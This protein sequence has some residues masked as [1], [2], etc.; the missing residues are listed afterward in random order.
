MS[1]VWA[2]C[3]TTS[4]NT[5]SEPGLRHGKFV[6]SKGKVHEGVRALLRGLAFAHIVRGEVP[7]FELRTL[8]HA[9]AGVED[10]HGHRSLGT[11]LGPGR[12]D[13]GAKKSRHG[14]SP[15]ELSTKS[16]ETYILLRHTNNVFLR[17]HTP[18]HDRGA[19]SRRWL[20][21]PGSAEHRGIRTGPSRFPVSS[22]SPS[23]SN[24]AKPHL[25]RIL[26]TLFA[27]VVNHILL[28]GRPVPAQQRRGDSV[29]SRHNRAPDASSLR[30][31]GVSY[32]SLSGFFEQLD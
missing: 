12:G 28:F 18:K 26:Y 23:P 15:P 2:A 10:G 7:E 19:Q 1:V 31:T 17:S 25:W 20:T 14:L 32:P 8:H 30:P 22:L 24:A 6:L 21:P 9:A 11:V 13:H 4:V 3:T 27:R 5:S 29:G 16:F